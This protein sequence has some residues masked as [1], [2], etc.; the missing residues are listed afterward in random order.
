M[1]KTVEHEGIGDRPE[2]ILHN[3]FAINKLPTR[4][5]LQPGIGRQNPKCRQVR[6]KGN[7]DGGQPMHQRRHPFPAKQHN[8]EET[9]L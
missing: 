3:E 8:A 1:Q 5:R 6:P 9:G 7:Q 2:V 4:W